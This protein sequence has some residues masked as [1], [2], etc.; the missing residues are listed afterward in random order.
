[1]KELIGK[2][3]NI[4]IEKNKKDLFYT[5]KV[6]NVT[7]THIY[8]IDKFNEPYVYKL[9]YLIEASQIH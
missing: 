2:T 4:H 1:M 6:I 9:T 5:A 3:C 7:D 8:F